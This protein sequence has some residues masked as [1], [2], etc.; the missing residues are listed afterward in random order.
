MKFNGALTFGHVA[1]EACSTDHYF[2]LFPQLA[3]HF[4]GHTDAYL[5]WAFPSVLLKSFAMEIYRG[6]NGKIL[7]GGLFSLYLGYF[8]PPVQFFSFLGSCLTVFPGGTKLLCFLRLSS[9]GQS[10][11]AAGPVIFFHDCYKLPRF[12]VAFKCAWACQISNFFR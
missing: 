9:P 5:R 12:T 10:P 2:V 1:M 6:D 8:F 7:R 3:L 4:Y 11:S